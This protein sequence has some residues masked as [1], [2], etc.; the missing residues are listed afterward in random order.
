MLIDDGHLQIPTMA[1]ANVTN[2][3]SGSV[4]LFFDS[5]N[6]NKLSQKDSAGAV[7]DLTLTGSGAD[8]TVSNNWTAGQSGRIATIGDGTNAITIASNVITLDFTKAVCFDLGVLTAGVGYT[9]G[10]PTGIANAKSFNGWIKVTQP[11]SGASPTLSY[12]SAWKFA[13]GTVPALSTAFNTEDF[14]DISSFS[15]TKVRTSLGKAWA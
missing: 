13:G 8:I 12:A 5:S 15:S 9:L 2:P 14:L 4:K 7:I 10:T 11:A 1:A 3:P 6:S